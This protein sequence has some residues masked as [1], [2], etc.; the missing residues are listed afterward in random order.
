MSG[1]GSISRE[2]IAG[3]F[4]SRAGTME[5]IGGIPSGWPQP[6]KPLEIHPENQVACFESNSDGGRRWRGSA[7]GRTRPPLGREREKRKRESEGE[8]ERASESER[9]RE[10]GRERERGRGRERERARERNRERERQSE[11]E[12]ERERSWEKR[13]RP[14]EG[15]QAQRA[16]RLT[17]LGH[18]RPRAAASRGGF[19]K[20]RLASNHSDVLAP[21]W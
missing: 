1:T 18:G 11:R 5:A 8:G 13:R 21:P 17:C 20:A 3:P 2:A 7:G 19:L 9:G 15:I 4:D 14:P 12:R 10:T 16:P 6:C